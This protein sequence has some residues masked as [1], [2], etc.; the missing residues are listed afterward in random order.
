[1]D[2][3]YHPSS[4]MLLGPPKGVSKEECN[5]VPATL[6]AEPT[7]IATFWQPTPDELAL[8]NANGRICLFVWGDQHP[9]VAMSVEKL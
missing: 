7:M 4:N 6:M 2:C 9:M 1:M 8:L 5:T 3:V